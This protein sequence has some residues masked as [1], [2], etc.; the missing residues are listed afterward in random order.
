MGLPVIT[1]T[2]ETFPSRVAGSLLT[3]IGTPELITYS[4]EDYYILALELANNNKKLEAI[5]NAIIS[6]RDTAPLF[7]SVRFTR[8][9]EKLYLQMM[10]SLPKIAFSRRLL[11]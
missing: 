5:R 4:R 8:D 11:N 6:N 3:A 10:D 7:D 2:G 9:L 1:C